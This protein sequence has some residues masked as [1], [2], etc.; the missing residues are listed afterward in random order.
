MTSLPKMKHL[1]EKK[2]LSIKVD[3]EIEELYRTG[4]NNGWD[5]SEIAR[6][7]L[8]EKFTKIANQLK[9]QAS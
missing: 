2:N 1:K 5:V 6:A 7:T 3:K 4:R 9:T 8:T